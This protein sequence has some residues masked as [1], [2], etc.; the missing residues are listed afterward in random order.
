M[1]L[2]PDNN[3][4]QFHNTLHT[5][6]VVSLY[7]SFQGKVKSSS[8]LCSK[9]TMVP[10]PYKVQYVA[11]PGDIVVSKLKCIAGARSLISLRT[12]TSS[13]RGFAGKLY[14]TFRRRRYRDSS[15]ALFHMTSKENHPIQKQRG[16]S[17]LVIFSFA[18]AAPH[19]QVPISE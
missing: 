16:F 2:Q 5:R 17:P 18:V 10:S 4:Q 9:V 15:L 1:L 14:C 11:Y 8:K 6:S 12:F 3:R 7:F 13:E 19:T